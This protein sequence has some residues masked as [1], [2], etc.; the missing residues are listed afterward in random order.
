MPD[1]VA[2]MV[3]DLAALERNPLEVALKTGGYVL[4]KCVEKP[5]PHD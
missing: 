1:G 4:G 3:Q 5:V 2:G